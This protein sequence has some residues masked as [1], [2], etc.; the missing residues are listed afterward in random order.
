MTSREEYAR[1]MRRLQETPWRRITIDGVFE[2][3]DE[4]IVAAQNSGELYTIREQARQDM[5]ELLGTNPQQWVGETVDLLDTGAFVAEAARPEQDRDVVEPLA[6]ES[7]PQA[8]QRKLGG[9]LDAL[10]QRS[11]KEDQN[12]P[13]QTPS[14]R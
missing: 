8:A 5:E 10:T 13:E 3:E 7:G 11:G 2:H 12:G 14:G 1:H 9:L 6:R 4:V